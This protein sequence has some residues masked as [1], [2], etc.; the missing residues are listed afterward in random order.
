MQLEQTEKG[1]KH[2]TQ[3][4]IDTC[5]EGKES[6]NIRQIVPLQESKYKMVQ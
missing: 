3:G 5:I 6:R 4:K 2:S 1:S